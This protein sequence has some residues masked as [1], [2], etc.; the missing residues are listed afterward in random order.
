VFNRAT[1]NP[2]WYIS[3]TEEF[4]ASQAELVY[5]I[6]RTCEQS[7]SDLVKYSNA[8]VSSGLCYMLSNSASNVVFSIIQKGVEE[9]DRIEAVKKL[10]ILYRDCLAKRCDPVLSHKNEA[11]SNPLWYICYMLWDISPLC[12]W[13]EV[14]IEVMEKALYL[15]NPACVESALHGLGHR[16]HQNPDIVEAVIDNF[17]SVCNGLRPELR[18]Y[19]HQ[20]RIGNIQ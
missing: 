2:D 12:Q 8:Q 14:V 20:A 10:T 19:A 18:L 1:T 6:G 7:G 9:Q 17:L 3:E 13:N 15:P 5:L 4:D 16:H 11:T